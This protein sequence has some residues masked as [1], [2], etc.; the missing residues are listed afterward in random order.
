L[1]KNLAKESISLI[2]T[3]G[4]GDEVD[5]EAAGSLFDYFKIK[6]SNSVKKRGTCIEN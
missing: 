4:F 6:Y 3:D 5:H 2:A 1:R